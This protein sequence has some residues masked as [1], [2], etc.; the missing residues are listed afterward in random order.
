MRG[1][2]QP[3]RTS[4]RPSATLLR[5]AEVDLSYT[6][7]PAALGERSD[8]VPGAVATCARAM[9]Q[10]DGAIIGSHRASAN[11]RKGLAPGQGRLA[12]TIWLRPAGFSSSFITCVR[13]ADSKFVE[14]VI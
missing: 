8:V 7:F 10:D 1:L 14:L 13:S 11:C 2:R 9:C 12:R 3:E 6:M 4:D 5:V